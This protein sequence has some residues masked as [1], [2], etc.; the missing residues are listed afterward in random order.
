MFGNL[1]FLTVLAVSSFLAMGSANAL[2][3]RSGGDAS[4]STTNSENAFTAWQGDV[5]SF[6]LDNMTGIGLGDCG[7][8]CTTDAGN[9]FTQGA[10]ALQGT[11]FTQGVVSGPNML[12]IQEDVEGYFTWTL[13]E[14][15]DAFGFFAFDTD[16]QTITINFNDGTA[17]ELTFASAN[18]IGC[19]GGTPGCSSDSLFWGVSGLSQKISSVTISALDEPGYSTWDRFVFGV[20][21][22]IPAALPLF[23]SGLAFFGFFARRR[24]AAA[25]A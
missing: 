7:G 21:V 10:G 3:V 9:T 20:T 18:D 16:G 1:K 24:D 6:T 8:V 13:P 19:T 23:L 12:L 4:G 22:P 15:V 5:S 2:T 14:P 17:Q 11:N 25:A